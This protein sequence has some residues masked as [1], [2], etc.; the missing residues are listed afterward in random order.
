V[1]V[2]VLLQVGYDEQFTVVCKVQL[3]PH[4]TFVTPETQSPVLLQSAGG[5][6][7]IDIK[8]VAV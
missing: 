2:D 4:E 5:G 7:G 8:P 3:T 1:H 6:Q